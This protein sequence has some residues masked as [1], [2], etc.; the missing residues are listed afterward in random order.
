VLFTATQPTNDE[1]EEV[2]R[3]ALLLSRY[4][5]SVV[6]VR[7]LPDGA[8][9]SVQLPD[10]GATA[11]A[12]RLEFNHGGTHVEGGACE[13]R[14]APLSNGQEAEGT[15]TCDAPFDRDSVADFVD[16][17]VAEDDAVAAA[18]AAVGANYEPWRVTPMKRYEM[19]SATAVPRWVVSMTATEGAFAATVDGT[20]GVVL[21]LASTRKDYKYTGYDSDFTQPGAG[22]KSKDSPLES[23]NPHLL[24]THP[25][26][27][28]ESPC[29][30]TTKLT[31]GAPPEFLKMHAVGFAICGNSRASTTTGAGYPFSP[32]EDTVPS[33][34]DLDFT[35][36]AGGGDPLG[37]VT[38]GSFLA[39]LGGIS[40]PV[41]P[42]SADPSYEG[43]TSNPN[44]ALVAP[45]HQAELQLFSELGSLFQWHRLI[46]MRSVTVGET[47][48]DPKSYAAVLHDGAA[49]GFGPDDL[50]IGGFSTPLITTPGRVADLVYDGSVLTHEYIPSRP[51]GLALR[52]RLAVRHDQR[53]RQLRA[54]PVV[55]AHGRARRNC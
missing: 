34:P 55:P 19:T 20:S 7:V 22:P 26:V 46:G 27:A 25:E 4:D 48:Q 24:A 5:A 13:V 18:K 12:W 54:V 31:P 30:N 29:P 17:T 14:V 38:F 39:P 42:T 28:G 10:V 16:F 8:T 52:S 41:I 33:R 3:G 53:L 32:P 6:G 35:N 51:V 44:G 1:L 23:A 45:T 50:K 21:D 15:I 2:V 11:A 9:R 37:P 49:A 43:P 36:A 40:F 47:Q